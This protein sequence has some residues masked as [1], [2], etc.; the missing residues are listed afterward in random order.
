MDAYIIRSA[1]T[2]DAY[3]SETR[4]AFVCGDESSASA[5]TKKIKGTTVKKVRKDRNE[6]LTICRDAGASRA[7]F[8][9]KYIDLCD[10]NTQRKFY[11]SSPTADLARYAHTKR[12]VY[13]ADMKSCTF[14]LAIRIRNRPSVSC[15]YATG[16]RKNSEWRFLAF[17]NMGE[18][19]RWENKA[20]K[21]W[22]PLLVEFS[23]MRRIVKNHG[24]ILN[25]ARIFFEMTPEMLDA[26]NEGRE[27]Q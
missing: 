1:H 18:Y 4:D 8:M 7:R 9:G 13:L 17:T 12:W 10:E 2:G 25:P 19:N 26:I 27:L 23:T 16:A 14:I 5:L 6:I 21:G 22:S 3:I 15:T 24:V 20:G 11:N